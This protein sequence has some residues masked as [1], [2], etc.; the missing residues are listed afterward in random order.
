MRWLAIALAAPVAAAPVADTLSLGGQQ[1]AVDSWQWGARGDGHSMLGASDRAPLLLKGRF[2]G[3]TK[4]ARYGGAQFA[5]SG[6]RVILSDVEVVD[7]SPD[8][9]TLK[10]RKVTVKG[11]NPETKEL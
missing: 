9:M 1:V 10:A 5:A 8:S 7:C 6:K 2:P 11:W 4:G 3:C